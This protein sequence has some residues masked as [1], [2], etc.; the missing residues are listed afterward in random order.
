MISI[1][2]KGLEL[3]FI[4]CLVNYFKNG[5]NIFL[6]FIYKTFWFFMFILIFN[7]SEY[8]IIRLI[9]YILN[10]KLIRIFFK[11]IDQNNLNIWDKVLNP[12]KI[13]L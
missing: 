4:D 5:F 13:D 6:N 2:I 11:L 9:W 8:I 10:K 1:K 3:Q 7:F 12:L